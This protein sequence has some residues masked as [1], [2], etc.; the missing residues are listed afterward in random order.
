MTRAN[1]LH[2]RE[3]LVTKSFPSP[4]RVGWEQRLKALSFAVCT[5]TAAFSIK[6]TLVNKL[7]EVQTTAKQ[8]RVVTHHKLT[9]KKPDLT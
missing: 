4:L 5:C 9:N 2:V 8:N 1:S 6:L 3:R 7:R